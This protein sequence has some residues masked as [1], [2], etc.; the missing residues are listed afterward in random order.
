MAGL[1]VAPD[2]RAISI[3]NVETGNGRLEVLF[4]DQN[5]SNTRFTPYRVS[6]YTFSVLD[7]ETTLQDD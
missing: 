3:G 7:L 5:H 4:K 1:N 6:I 2:E